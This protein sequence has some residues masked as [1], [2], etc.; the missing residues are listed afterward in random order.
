MLVLHNNRELLYPRSHRRFSFPAS[1]AAQFWS[2]M[3][4]FASA[5]S[6]GLTP[7]SYCAFLPRVSLASLAPARAKALPWRPRV[8]TQ[9][10]RTPPQLRLKPAIPSQ[11]CRCPAVTAISAFASCLY[12]LPMRDWLLRDLQALRE[13]QAQVAR[14]SVRV[15]EQKQSHSPPDISGIIAS[16]KNRMQRCGRLGSAVVHLP[17][18]MDTSS[19]I[20]R[21]KSCGATDED[22]ASDRVVSALVVRGAAACNVCV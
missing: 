1:Y 10:S 9:H 18:S 3:L 22:A 19:V 7:K 8:H 20:E 12:R 15:S 17:S 6:A 21:L 11:L 5:R 4:L 2:T 14:P 13:L 16:T